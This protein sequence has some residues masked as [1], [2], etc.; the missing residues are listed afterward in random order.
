[1]IVEACG[2][3]DPTTFYDWL[4]NRSVSQGAAQ[5]IL[6]VLKE[7]PHLK[8]YPARGARVM[9]VAPKD[10]AR[11][12]RGQ[13]GARPNVVTSQRNPRHV[14]ELSSDADRFQCM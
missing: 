11:Q 1:M 12:M 5:K 3:T 10:S 6:R 13:S 4:A 9:R 7:K 14:A 2:W 8:V